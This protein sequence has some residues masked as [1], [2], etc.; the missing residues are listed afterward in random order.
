MRATHKAYIASV[1]TG[2]G[3]TDIP[4]QAGDVLFG[5]FEF[6]KILRCPSGSLPKRIQK[7]ISLG[8][9]EVKSNNHCSIVSIKNW[10]TY[11]DIMEER[12]HPRKHRGNT[13]ETHTSIRTQDLSQKQEH[14]VTDKR[15]HPPTLDEVSQYCKERGNG[16]DCIKWHSYYA[17]NGWK[18]GRNSMKN[19]K[20][21][22]VTWERNENRVSE[23]ASGGCSFPGCKGPGS[24]TSRS[25]AKF[26]RAHIT[27]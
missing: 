5:R 18:V 27:L 6:A 14:G 19:W 17:A 16:I 21:A 4:L 1:S 3:Y 11:A 15:F 22:I 26:C 7:L 25:G 13:E 2:T 8:N 12:K 10:D 9:I 24:Q 20:A 23:D